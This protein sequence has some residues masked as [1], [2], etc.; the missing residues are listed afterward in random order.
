MMLT[1]QG[2][3]SSHMFPPLSV[4]TRHV[5]GRLQAKANVGVDHDLTNHTRSLVQVYRLF[6]F[7]PQGDPAGVSSTAPNDVYRVPEAPNGR[8]GSPGHV[9]TASQP[10]PR[11]SAAHDLQYTTNTRNYLQLLDRGQGGL[12][13]RAGSY[14]R[15]QCVVVADLKSHIQISVLRDGSNET[16]HHVLLHGLSSIPLPKHVQHFTLITDTIMSLQSITQ[17]NRTWHDSKHSRYS[18]VGHTIIAQPT[19]TH[20]SG[21]QLF[22][23]AMTGHAK[24]WGSTTAAH[25][26]LKRCCLKCSNESR[27]EKMGLYRHDQMGVLLA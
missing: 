5:L 23:V 17:M 20:A 10:T 13:S 19:P 25:S 24:V 14:F 12:I 3:T 9:P 16:T 27:S 1:L 2:C 26:S 4:C 7:H 18:M 8:L 22:T 6:G 15:A 21:F 11:V